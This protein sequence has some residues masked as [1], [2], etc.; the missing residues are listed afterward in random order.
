MMTVTEAFQKFRTKLELTQKEQD[1]ASRRQ[2]EIRE[3]MDSGFKLADD[4]LTGSY[5]RWTKTSR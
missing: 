2:K 4:F 1:D 3:H 5:R